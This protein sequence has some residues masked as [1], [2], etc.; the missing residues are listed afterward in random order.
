[1]ISKY[2]QEI[3]ETVLTELKKNENLDKICINFLDPL[4]YYSFRKIY[5]YFLLFL[6]IHILILILISFIILFLF[7]NKFRS[8]NF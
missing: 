6:V 3:L 1:M 4:I 8:I 2:S 7:K 5:P